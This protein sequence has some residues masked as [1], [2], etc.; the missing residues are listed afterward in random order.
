M[1]PYCDQPPA[2]T[3]EGDGVFFGTVATYFGIVNGY[4][5]GDD[6]DDENQVG[7]LCLN[8][9][10]GQVFVN[11]DIGGDECGDDGISLVVENS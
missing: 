9:N 2:D 4:L 3:P 11:P 1:G 6:C 8:R 7:C 10:T 5:D